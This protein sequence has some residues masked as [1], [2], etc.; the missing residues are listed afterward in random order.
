MRIRCIVGES[1]NRDFDVLTTFGS[2]LKLR[3]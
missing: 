3:F 2:S 1:R